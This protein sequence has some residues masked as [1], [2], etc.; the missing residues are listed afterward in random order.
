VQLCEVG[1]G[2]S[3]AFGVCRA[4]AQVDRQRDGVGKAWEL[5][6]NG[7]LRLTA[8]ERIQVRL[9]DWQL[10]LWIHGVLLDCTADIVVSVGDECTL[11][12]RSVSSSIIQRGIVLT[13]DLD[14]H[15]K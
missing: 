9:G 13:K 10:Q 15:S 14:A 5:G 11:Q 4:M 6:R 8:E 1:A 2:R 12:H 7:L 3:C